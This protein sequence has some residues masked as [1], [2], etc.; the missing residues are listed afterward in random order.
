MCKFDPGARMRTFCF[1]LKSGVTPTAPYLVAGM[2][3][4]PCARAA[5]SSRAVMLEAGGVPCVGGEASMVLQ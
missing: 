3:G 2:A 5:A 4:R 1:F